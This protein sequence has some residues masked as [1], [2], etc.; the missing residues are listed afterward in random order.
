MLDAAGHATGIC[1]IFYRC[2]VSTKQPNHSGGSRRKVSLFTSLA[3]SV[4]LRRLIAL[5]RRAHHWLLVVL[6]ILLELRLLLKLWLMLD[7]TT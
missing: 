5:R 1:Q 7:D 4:L 6:R 3:V 2:R